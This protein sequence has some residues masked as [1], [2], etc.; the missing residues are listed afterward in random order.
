MQEI[1]ANVKARLG[2]AQAENVAGDS[3]NFQGWHLKPM[4]IVV[5]RVLADNKEAWHGNPDEPGTPGTLET[6][7]L[8]PST[9]RPV[10]IKSSFHVSQLDN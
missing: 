8:T 4:G 9:A 1:A 5:T 7:E 3:A 6:G 2:K 10:Y